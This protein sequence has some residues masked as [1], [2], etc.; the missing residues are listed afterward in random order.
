MLKLTP[1]YASVIYQILWIRQ[2][3][4][5]SVPFRENFSVTVNFA[6]SVELKHKDNT[7][8]SVA[9][10]PCNAQNKNETATFR[11]IHWS[12]R[13][14]KFCM[15]KF[16]W[17]EGGN[18]RCSNIE[19]NNPP[20]HP[21]VRDLIAFGGKTQIFDHILSPLS[22]CFE[23]QIVFSEDDQNGEVDPMYL[24]GFDA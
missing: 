3:H 8:Q 22:Q 21:P 13:N 12:L 7:C 15:R 23:S 19:L 9:L 16:P 10:C 6:G 5:I 1:I 2:I 17:G 20:P 24:F 14:V 4:W 11:Y 18:L